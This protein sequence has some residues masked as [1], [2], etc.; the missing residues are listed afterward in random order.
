MHY[1]QYIIIFLILLIIAFSII[2]LNKKD[3]HIEMNKLV[4]LLGGLDN[5]IDTE[6]SESRFKVTLKDVNKANKDAIVALGAKGIV[7]IENQLK[8]ILGEDSKKLKA[9][10]DNIK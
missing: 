9:Y 2:K 4:N 7:E 3:I 5:I 1:G 10:I 6:Y 8:I